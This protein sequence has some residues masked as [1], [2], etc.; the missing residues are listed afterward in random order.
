MPRV[1]HLI[2]AAALLI[3]GWMAWGW[4]FP[5][6]EAQIR[7][8]LDR[9]AEAVSSDGS[10]GDLARLGRVAG[11]R[12]D[13]HPDLFVD[14]GPPFRELRGREAVIAAAA[15]TGGAIRELDVAFVDVAITVDEDGQHGR[16]TLVAEARF[17]DGDGAGRTYDA[18]ELDLQFQRYE[19]RWVITEVALVSG[20]KPLS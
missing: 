6:D 1:A 12:Q 3:G 18:R 13:V 10:D 20:L 9:V 8:L 4:L 16:A 11:L 2:T 7:A 17:R 14:A 19:D 15:R 5:S